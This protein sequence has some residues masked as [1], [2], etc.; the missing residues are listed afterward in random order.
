MAISK[1]LSITKIRGFSIFLQCLGQHVTWK[2]RDLLRLKEIQGKKKTYEGFCVSIRRTLSAA[3]TKDLQ[4]VA[5][6]YQKSIDCATQSIHLIVT[7]IQKAV[8]QKASPCIRGENQK[9]S[10]IKRLAL[11]GRAGDLHNKSG[12]RK[13]KSWKLLKLPILQDK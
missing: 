9:T 8:K 6:F 13:N 12:R 1:I 10:Y 3:D 7:H 2:M 4:S 11:S 5:C